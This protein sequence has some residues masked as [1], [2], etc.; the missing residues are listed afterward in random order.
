MT[1]LSLLLSALIHNVSQS[2]TDKFTLAV[3]PET[4]V[5][6]LDLPASL[7]FLNLI[8]ACV[9]SVLEHENDLPDRDYFIYQVELAVHEAC[10]NIIEHA[11]AES[12]GR[13]KLQLTI[14]EAP[15]RL[16][17]DIFDTGIPFDTNRL[18]KLEIG[19]PKTRG[20]GLYLI[21]QL[22]DKVTYLGEP[23][24]NHWCLEKIF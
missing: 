22:M 1:K 17:V 19:E 13:V 11:Y 10:T 9:R 21:H 18:Q 7:K 20:Y 15:R 24:K 2:K 16:I 4:E 6:N 3:I 23:G 14:E 8:G 12:S 5:V